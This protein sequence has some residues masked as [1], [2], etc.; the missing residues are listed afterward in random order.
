MKHDDLDMELQ[1]VEE[2]FDKDVHFQVPHYQRNYSWEE[3]HVKLLLDDLAGA[4]SGFPD[5]V[6]LLGQVLLSPNEKKLD[7]LDSDVSSFELIDGQQRATTVYL[8]FVLLL[9][10]LNPEISRKSTTG[11][12]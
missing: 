1:E 2:F 6:Y 11:T 8:L 4:M 7:G 12:R 3:D 10:S 9:H 5:D